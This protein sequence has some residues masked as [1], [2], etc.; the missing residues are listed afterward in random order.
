MLQNVLRELEQK[1]PQLD[2]LVHTAENLRADTN[3]QQ[4]HGKGEFCTNH[5]CIDILWQEATKVIE[6]GNFIY[7]I[8]CVLFALIINE[9]A[10]KILPFEWFIKKYAQSRFPCSDSHERSLNWCRKFYKA[11]NVWIVHKRSSNTKVQI[12]ADP[13]FE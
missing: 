1:K 8:I 5:F 10:I 7:K 2:E 4:L 3:R 6:V 13:S 12:K 11:G 9:Y